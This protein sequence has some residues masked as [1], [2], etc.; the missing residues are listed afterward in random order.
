MRLWIVALSGLLTAGAAAAQSPAPPPPPSCAA[1]EYRQLDFWVGEWDAEYTNPDG[2]TGRGQNRIT[3]NEYGDCVIAEYFRQPGGGTGGG[4][5]L[6]TSYSIYDQVTRS[7]RQM[8]VDNQGSM[9]DLRG[10]PVSGQR[11]S[12][13][14]VNVEPRGNPP[15]SLRM[16]WEDVTADAFVWRWQAQQPDGSWR[17]LWVVRYRRRAAP[18]AS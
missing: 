8:W 16:T 6:G 11:H 9:F 18:T 17:D 10:G 7:W 1:P 14:L 4:D 13:E 2:S 15:R 12:F 5:F 3:R